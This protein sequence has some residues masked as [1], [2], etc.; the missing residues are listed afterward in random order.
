[1]EEFATQIHRGSHSLSPPDRA[2][3]AV[4]SPPETPQ[5][6][7]LPGPAVDPSPAQ[8]SVQ[9][10]PR[11]ASAIGP[12]PPASVEAAQAAP[13]PA[14]VVPS[15]EP[16]LSAATWT[17]QDDGS[18][19]APGLD[20][21]AT[22]PDAAPSYDWTDKTVPDA[23]SQGD[24]KALANASRKQVTNAVKATKSGGGGL[25]YGSRRSTRVRL[26]VF[27]LIVLLVIAI[28]GF[29]LVAQWRAARDASPFPLESNETTETSEIPLSLIGATP[30]DA[31]P[32]DASVVIADATPATVI[33]ESPPPDTADSPAPRRQSKARRVRRQP[34]RDSRVT[35]APQQNSRGRAQLSILADPPGRA[36]V[37]GRLVGH[38]TPVR[39][40]RLSPGVHQVRVV[41]SSTRQ[42]QS[43][44]ITLDP[45]EHEVVRF[46]AR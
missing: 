31:S 19:S 15:E 46:S 42:A 9:S 11:A 7:A 30:V 25:D 32:A 43:R 24:V 18:N 22:A 23:A 21:S 5:P 4:A 37:D 41:F 6:A 14:F 28:A 40:V 8:P 29:A 34:R 2:A 45:G 20:A 33:V 36:Y 16:P 39:G 3:P 26:V 1:M 44:R 10:P 27:A 35:P 12:S 17:T 38:R 13:P